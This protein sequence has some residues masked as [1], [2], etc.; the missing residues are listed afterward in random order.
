MP[1]NTGNKEP[2]SSRG[3]WSKAA[4]TARVRATKFRIKGQI[5]ISAN[6]RGAEEERRTGGAAQD[7]QTEDS[8][9]LLSSVGR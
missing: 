4:N 2:E 8:Q 7:N 5:K 1:E 6:V 3:S 9:R